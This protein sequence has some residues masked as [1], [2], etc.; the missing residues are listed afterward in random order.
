MT[1]I[2]RAE[3]IIEEAE[4]IAS[5]SSPYR[6]EL[7]FPPSSNTAYPTGKTGKRFLSTKGKKWYAEALPEIEFVLMGMDA[8]EKISMAFHFAFPDNRARDLLNYVKLPQDAVC[9]ILGVDDN[10][11]IVPDMTLR[12][13]GVDKHNPRC[14]VIISA[15]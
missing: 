8:P 6:I 3:Q 7:P 14:I 13:L 9:D 15:I 4:R 12:S 11:T 10:H 2:D 5:A 1:T